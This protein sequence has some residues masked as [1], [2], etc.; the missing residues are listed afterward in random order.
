M[1]LKT[2]ERE[3]RATYAAFAAVVASILREALK[4]V[5]ALRLQ[6]VTQRA[7]AVDS[8]ERKL[9]ARGLSES[10]TIEDE[11][12]DLAGCRA[13][14][15]TNSDVN[16]FLR[17]RI[18]RDNFDIVDVKVHQ[19]QRKVGDETELYISIHYLV[20][21]SAARAEL[22][23]YA[24]FAGMRCEIQIQ[25][26][27]NHSWAEMAH[28]TIYKAP[29]LVSGF[30]SRGFKGIRQRLGKIMGKYLL[31]AGYEF[32][33]IVRDFEALRE[34]REIFDADPLKEIADAADNDQR[35]RTLHA[36]A[37][38]IPHYDDLRSAWPQILATL[39]S[40]VGA[41]RNQPPKEVK[42]PDGMPRATPTDV[43]RT[44]VERIRPYRF[45]DID[46]TL[47]A[48]L[49][50][51]DLAGD[52]DERKLVSDLGVLLAKHDLSAWEKVGHG[53]QSHLVDRIS[54]LPVGQRDGRRSLIAA[55]L[56]AC[57]GPELEGTSS[58]SKSVTW[59][60]G[61]LPVSESL[62]AM[63][64]KAIA[65]L[66]EQYLRSATEKERR[67]LLG[68]MD[69]A[70]RTPYGS[71][72]SNEFAAMVAADTSDV[73]DLLSS[74]AS[75]VSML[76]RQEIEDHVFRFFKRYSTLPPSMASDE[77]LVPIAKE[78][79]EKATCFRDLV[80]SDRDFVVFKTLVG[81]RSVFAPAWDDPDFDFRQAKLHREERAQEL[82]SQVVPQTAAEWF[83][84]L[85]LCAETKSE[86]MA[87][88]PTFHE[89]LSGLSKAQPEIARDYI[90]R[91]GPD[92][93]AFLPAMLCGL[94]NAHDPES[95]TMIERWI[96]EG[97]NLSSILIAMAALEVLPDEAL[98]ARTTEAAV[99]SGDA[100]A[101]LN[102]LR[103]AGRLFEKSPNRYLKTSFYPA[104]LMLLA[105]GDQRWLHMHW[106]SWLDSGAIESMDTDMAKL[107]LQ[108]MVA[109][110]HLRDDAEYVVGGLAKKWP[111]AVL[112]FLGDRQ[113]FDDSPNDERPAKY[114]ALPYSVYSLGPQLRKHV[115][116][117]LSAARAWYDLDPGMFRFRGGHFVSE[118]FEGHE[119][120]LKEVIEDD[121]LGSGNRQDIEFLVSL[122][123]ALEGRG[124]ALELVRAIVAQ[125]PEDDPLLADLRLVMESS[126][127][128]TGEYGLADLYEKRKQVVEP[129]LED[130]NEGVQAFAREFIR[131]INNDIAEE[132]GRA[133]ASIAERR[134]D[135]DEAIDDLL[136][137]DA[138]AEDGVA[139]EQPSAD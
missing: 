60:R 139:P 25:T 29:T 79:V 21:L 56:K 39:T 61:A 10:Q 111:E 101:A 53:V 103:T 89:F 113:R 23:E 55:I 109:V 14:F 107:T 92:L 28:D 104:L 87:T 16:G 18:V 4:S 138:E 110:P 102:A 63:R 59:K 24:Q 26:I 81:F 91:M 35:M 70:T 2:Y 88:F 68:A 19:P 78:I 93:A 20:R 137:L 73:I 125:L 47:D 69:E 131:M 116:K 58:D 105:R 83:R 121:F 86:D 3:G 45:V 77:S 135:Y 115:R 124:G 42:T 128:V 12:K 80:N 106:H 100:D 7:K 66:E 126:G 82:L 1:D 33:K 62:K 44:V 120:E 17:S 136:S 98:V 6:L 99:S 41:S 67:E 34:A 94:M 30:G 71:N 122:L 38:A 64:K 74:A 37:K 108:G 134:L 129:W 11:I 119:S 85:T 8:L 22:V 95:M 130:A 52:H 118:V 57:L 31:P 96:T 51:F 72:Y 46:L 9:V 50:L 43:L 133:R 114:E 112:E 27:L 97:K 5:P 117:T 127:V 32:D 75:G 40:A 84:V 36:L 76:H 13:V 49:A 65:I 90:G 123:L 15:Y 132:Q 48:A 54:A